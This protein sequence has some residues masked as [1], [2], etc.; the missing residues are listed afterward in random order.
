MAAK[1]GLPCVDMHAYTNAYTEEEVATYYATDKLHPSNEGY[2]K[3]AQV[4]YDAVKSLNTTFDTA[5]VTAYTFDENAL[6]SFLAPE[7]L[8]A[9]IKKSTTSAGQDLGFRTKIS[10]VVKTGATIVE[11]GT[12]FSKYKSD[13]EE[14]ILNRMVYSETADPNK[15]VAYA[16]GFSS[17]VVGMEYIAGLGGANN[18]QVKEAY[19][20]RSY[21]KFSDGSIYYSI[22]DYNDAAS[23][24]NRKG[25]V[26]GYACRS[27]VSIAK[28]MVKFLAVNGIENSDIASYNASTD[29]L[30]FTETAKANYD[31]IFGFLTAHKNDIYELV[32]GG[33]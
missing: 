17:D 19:I 32:E 16:R 25:V 23:Y 22:N 30:T 27:V 26:N 12:I 10:N 4:F 21:V 8:A 29:T 20:A 9:T 3:M 1:Y 2:T 18:E 31:L 11:Y 15:L 5:D 14:T 33:N 24:S 13:N 6:N 7:M 28:E